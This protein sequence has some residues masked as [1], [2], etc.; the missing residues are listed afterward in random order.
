[1]KALNTI[2]IGRIQG[3]FSCGHVSIHKLAQKYGRSL[4]HHW[5]CDPIHEHST[6][7]ESRIV[8]T[9]HCATTINWSTS[10]RAF[11]NERQY[12][13]F[14]TATQIQQELQNSH[15]VSVS[16]TTVLRDLRS[17][18]QCRV[19]KRVPIREPRVLRDRLKFA[20]KLS[21]NTAVIQR[22]VFSDE[23]TVSI[24]DHSSRTMWVKSKQTVIP[25]ER[26]R[27]QNIPRVMIWAAVG[28]G[29][30]SPIVLFPQ[31]RKTEDDEK[32]TFRLNTKSY[33]RRCLAVVVPELVR[34]NRVFQQDGATCHTS[35]GSLAYLRRKNV[36]NIARIRWKNCKLRSKMLGK[37]FLNV[38]STQFVPDNS[39]NCFKS[40][41]QGELVCNVFFLT[42]FSAP[43]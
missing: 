20:Q 3:E 38:K 22:I 9:C 31:T 10:Q 13:K 21:K 34:R 27:L 33:I 23:H 36:E 7:K 5:P 43:R 29:F 19:R 30:K 42:T 28:T 35:G 12:P 16:K 11:I 14:C 17:G 1:M 18:F 40:C 4:E 8:A 32:V 15:A 37:A 25:R 26:R 41:K 6:A 2:E 39:G 24:N